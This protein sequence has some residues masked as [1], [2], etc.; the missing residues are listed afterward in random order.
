LTLMVV[1][2]AIS[3]LFRRIWPDPTGQAPKV[4]ENGPSAIALRL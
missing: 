2:L 4:K 1:A 3:N